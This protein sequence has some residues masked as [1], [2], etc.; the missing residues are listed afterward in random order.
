MSVF[1]RFS[2]VLLEKRLFTGDLA[3]IFR[4]V[5]ARQGCASLLIRRLITHDRLR[6]RARVSVDTVAA[7]GDAVGWPCPGSLCAWLR[8]ATVSPFNGWWRAL[9][10]YASSLLDPDPP[11]H[12]LLAL[13]AMTALGGNSGWQ[14]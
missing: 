6:R 2:R 1:L 14:L 12:T 3:K 8:G 11:H 4:W 5:L 7:F 10:A 13:I 9:A